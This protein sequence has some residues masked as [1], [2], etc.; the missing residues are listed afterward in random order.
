MRTIE[1]IVRFDLAVSTFCLQ[2]KFNRQVA[3]ISKTISRSGDGDLYLILGL[4]CWW[5]HPQVGGM[6]LAAGLV[7]FAFEL[8][9]YWTL[10]NGFK[11]RRPSDLCELLSAFITPSD[12]YSLPSGHTAAGF[13]M[14][15]LIS[16][17]FPQWAWLGWCWGTL[18]G[19]SRILLGVH[20]LTDVVIGAGLGISCAHL[21]LHILGIS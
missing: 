2:H 8:P 11:R 6:F 10:K 21:A 15:T 20:F 9:I 12:R 4:L 5:L 19:A 17:F 18:I 1:S 7:A 3:T 13:V 14:A 16:T